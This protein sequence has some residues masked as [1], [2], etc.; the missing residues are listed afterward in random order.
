[1][2]FSNWGRFP[3]SQGELFEASSTEDVLAI[4]N[5]HDYLIARGNGRSYGDAGLGPQ[6]LKL[7]NPEILDWDSENHVIECTSSTTLAELLNYLVPKGFILPVLPGHAQVTVGGAIASDIHGKNHHVDGNFSNGVVSFELLLALGEIKTC[8][9]DN[10]DNLFWN[11]FGA[12]GLTGVITAVKIKCSSISTT[13]IEA[14]IIKSTDLNFLLHNFE[15]K[16]TI[17]I[18]GCLVGPCPS[19]Y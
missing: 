1:M 18:L 12:M 9:R 19:L 3:E 10:N 16:N 13:Y 6:M 4:A 2:R 11:T 17:Q 8:S 5:D 7:N 15:T 14:E